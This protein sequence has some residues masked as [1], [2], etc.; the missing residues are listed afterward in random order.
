MV[1]KCNNEK[2]QTCLKK[3][4]KEHLDNEVKISEPIV[5]RNAI[6]LVNINED[7]KEKSD[8]EIIT[9]IKKQNE[10]LNNNL[11]VKLRKRIIFEK[12]KKN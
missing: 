2:S 4:I 8:E 1:I 12:K 11:N 6:K 10:I 5:N 7:M 9:I 3:Q